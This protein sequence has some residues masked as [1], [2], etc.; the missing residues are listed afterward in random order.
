MKFNDLPEADKAYV[1]MELGRTFEYFFKKTTEER[2]K[3]IGSSLDDLVEDLYWIGQISNSN[4]IIITN[5]YQEMI[6]FSNYF[7]EYL[8]KDVRP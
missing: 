6:D 2:I 3:N 7:R 4:D 8:L 1:E 5:T